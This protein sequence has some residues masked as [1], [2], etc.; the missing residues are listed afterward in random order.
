[1]PRSKSKS[2]A[3]T[4][5]LVE[6][7]KLPLSDVLAAADLNA[8]LAWLELTEEEQK[9]VSFW[10]LNRY[11]SSVKGTREDQELA[12]LKTNEYLNKSL[13]TI[14]SSIQ[15]GHPFLLWQIFCLCG[16]TNKIE[17]HPWI[18]PKNKKSS[19]KNDAIKFLE[20]LYPNAKIDELELLARMST[21]EQLQNL[22]EDH[23][24]EKVKF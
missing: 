21:K 13:K 3:K 11:M 24:I 6:S 1:M 22:A 14:S 8:K 16:N 20:N 19:S 4:S 5:T 7:K 23:G 15:K 9:S 2:T 18:A 12:V 10:V 17:Y